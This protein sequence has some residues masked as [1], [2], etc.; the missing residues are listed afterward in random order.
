MLRILP[1]TTGI[2]YAQP[3]DVYFGV[4]IWKLYQ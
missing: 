1:N 2:Y 4:L 3:V